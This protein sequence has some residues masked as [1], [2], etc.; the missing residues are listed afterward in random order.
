MQIAG[1][2][3]ERFLTIFIAGLLSGALVLL[4]CGGLAALTWFVLS[5]GPSQPTVAIISPQSNT[6]FLRGET[7]RV[8]ARA[9][10]GGLIERMELY[11]DGELVDTQP[12]PSPQA[13]FTSQLEWRAA[14]R[15]AR[16]LE[17]IAYNTQGASSQPAAIILEVVETVAELT[18]LIGATPIT[19]PTP[20]AT[21]TSTVTL[22]P[23]PDPVINEFSANP[24]S[25]DRGGTSR[26]TWDVDF[27]YGGV[28]LFYP[29]APPGGEGVAGEGPTAYK[30]VRPPV[31]TTYRLVA[32]GAAGQ[33]VSREVTVQV[34]L[35]ITVTFERVTLD[36]AAP[37]FRILGPGSDVYLFLRID[38][39]E[40]R[41]PATGSKDMDEGD[42]ADIG[43]SLAVTI[44][45]ANPLVVEVVGWDA[46]RPDPDDSLGTARG[47]FGSSTNWGEGT[48]NLTSTG[49]EGRFTIRITITVG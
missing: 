42:S 9:S 13:I 19:T 24:S 10:G 31:T 6:R 20:E 8:Q 33:E 40:R 25:I 1:I 43:E 3:R 2:P 47:E 32:R 27:A 36:K 34:R 48:Q 26:L 29:G 11:V 14:S 22:T 17:V 38:G 7:V 28:Y 41:W 37:D 5:P 18:P 4:A 44:D 46:D 12:S 30:D 45:T 21:P 39:Q 15:G 35:P 16:T 23:L 49:G